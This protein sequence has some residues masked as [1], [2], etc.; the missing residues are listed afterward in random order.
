MKPPVSLGFILGVRI[1]SYSDNAA[2][3]WRGDLWNQNELEPHVAIEKTNRCYSLSVGAFDVVFPVFALVCWVV[4]R[5]LFFVGEVK[6]LLVAEL[7]LN[8]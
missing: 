6:I 4:Q 1:K 8:N 7:K 5:F 3:H 2:K